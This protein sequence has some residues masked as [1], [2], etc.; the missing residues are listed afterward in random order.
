MTNVPEIRMR[1]GIKVLCPV[2]RDEMFGPLDRIREMFR[3]RRPNCRMCWRAGR[4]Y[5]VDGVQFVAEPQGERTVACLKVGHGH[6]FI[7]RINGGTATWECSVE[8]C[9]EQEERPL[10]P[11]SF[12]DPP[13][14]RV[15][16]FSR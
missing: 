8:G 2:H 6:K 7:A 10:E 14:S 15:A 11:A 5:F 13:R 3:C 9:S 4:G 12:W 1:T 16:S